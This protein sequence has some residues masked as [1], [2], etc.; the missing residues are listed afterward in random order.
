MLL[1]TSASPSPA[2]CL[3]VSVTL[4]YIRGIESEVVKKPRESLA[5]TSRDLN[6]GIIVM[7]ID[8]VFL[9]NLYLIYEFFIFFE[10]SFVTQILLFMFTTN[11]VSLFA[12]SC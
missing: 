3:S 6:V 2:V 8:V 4:H 5:F 9:F 7:N 12:I 10:V 11:I 1:L